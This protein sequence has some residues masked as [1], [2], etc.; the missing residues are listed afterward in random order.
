MKCSSSLLFS[1]FLLQITFL[2]SGAQSLDTLQ[3]QQVEVVASSALDTDNLSVQKIDQAVLKV[4]K[5]NTIA[6]LLQQN[7]IVFIK[8][9]GPG[10]LATAS[11]RGTTANHTQVLWNGVPVNAPNNGQVDFNRLP[12]F[13][14]DEAQLARGAQSASQQGGFGGLIMLN[15]QSVFNEGFQLD[16]KQAVG[17]FNS[18][19]SYADFS[20]SNNKVQLRTRIFRT[21]S[22]N[23]FEYLNTAPI[24]AKKMKQQQ[25]DFVDKGVLQEFHWQKGQSIL[26]FYSWHQ[27]N[28]RNLPPIMTNLERGGNPEERQDD[29][30]HRNILS[31]KSYWPRASLEFKAA[32]FAEYQNYFLRT[33]SN[34]GG[35]ETVSLIESK[36]NLQF[37]QQEINFSQELGSYW[38]LE[39]STL[40]SRQTA[41]STYFDSKK[42]RD[43]LALRLKMSYQHEKGHLLELGAHQDDTDGQLMAFSP[44]AHFSATIPGAERW[45]YAV[46]ISKNYHAPSLNDLYWYPGGNQNLMAEKALQADFSLRHE[47]RQERYQIAITAGL[48]ASR[49]SD[50]IQWRPTAYRYWVPENISMVFARGAELFLKAGFSHGKFRHSLQMNY[51]FTRTTDESPL[52]QI[53]N[54]QGRQLIYIPMH[55]ANA[56]YQL[57][58]NDWQISYTVVYTGERNTSL[59]ENEFY[60][61]AL[62]AYT[63]H[64][65]SLM[66]SWKH[67]SASLQLNNIF[68]KDYQAIRWRAMPGRNFAI[69]LS[70]HF[71]SNH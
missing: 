42:Q 49:I 7:S 41:F 67:F 24:P 52:A 57:N 47:I 19:G 28:D 60:G 54:T 50:W 10:S 25:A 4:N 9:Y 13:F 8:D 56:L 37:W 58:F 29:R 32:W 6:N 15:N 2:R 22:E 35:Y 68:N 16:L 39:T 46:G 43:Q 53:D 51:A 34:Y 71:N 11:F 14:V 69:A 17:S 1:V 62:P 48:Y 30:F 31:Y 5:I 55:H 65:G 27:W 36:N 20:W 38:T 33:T 61:F 70:Y 64:H 12:V 40:I 21:S 26:S 59:N 18:L 45:H 23:D 66:K 63:L 3:L 44:F